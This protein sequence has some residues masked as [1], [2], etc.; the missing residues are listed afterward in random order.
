MSSCQPCALQKSNQS[1]EQEEDEAGKLGS[2]EEPADES[3]ARTVVA[4]VDSE[5][6]IAAGFASKKMM[7]ISAVLVCHFGHVVEP[8]R[9]RRT[10]RST[11]EEQS[12]CNNSTQ[13]A[14]FHSF[15]N[16]SC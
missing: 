7:E 11:L 6:S 14:A 15:S 8:E 5:L 3:H 12:C 2:N 13:V 16:L 10:G 1:P 9:S 4:N